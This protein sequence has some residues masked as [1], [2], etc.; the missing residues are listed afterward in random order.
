MRWL[1]TFSKRALTVTQQLAIALMVVALGVPLQT[2]AAGSGVQITELQPNPVSISDVDG[3][4]VELYNSSSTE[5]ADLTNWKLDNSMLK[6][7]APNDLTIEAL[8]YFLICK[9]GDSNTNGGVDCDAT[10]G[11][12]LSNSGDTVLLEDASDATVDS[13]TYTAGDAVPGESIIVTTDEGGGDPEL[14]NDSSN[15]YNTTT[16]TDYGTPGAAAPVVTIDKL[17]TNDPNPTLSGTVTDDGSVVGVTVT[18]GSSVYVAI[19][20]N[21]AGTWS[22]TVSGALAEGT[23]DV[24]VNATDNEGLIGTDNTTDEVVVDLTAPT[25]SNFVSPA[26]GTAWVDII[27]INGRTTEDTALSHVMIYAKLTGTPDSA[28]QLIAA[29]V[30]VVDEGGGLYSWAMKWDP[31]ADPFNVKAAQFDFKVVGV[32]VAGNVESTGLVSKVS[33][34]TTPQPISPANGAFTNQTTVKLVWDDLSAS[35]VDR[36]PGEKEVIIV[37]DRS[38][39]EAIRLPIRVDPTP[40]LQEELQHL[41][42]QRAVVLK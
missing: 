34:F 35:G 25:S 12:T 11:F 30:A 23:Y 28:Y 4:W 9:N 40:G 7:V 37:I 42:G 18:I 16:A 5:D 10:A 2:M 20:D 27:G 31:T 36:A 17:L 33:F 29:Q 13:I 14:S 26:E 38:S 24:T 41:Y 32:D 39:R 1:A 21:A 22:A 8:S 3:E 19:V 15:A 6:A